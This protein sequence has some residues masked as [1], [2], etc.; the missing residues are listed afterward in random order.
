[1][2]AINVQVECRTTA[3]LRLSENIANEIAD[4]VLHFA[5]LIFDVSNEWRSFLVNK[6][7]R[8]ASRL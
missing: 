2:G 8:L 7:S 4:V 6:V 5:V 3:V 1:M